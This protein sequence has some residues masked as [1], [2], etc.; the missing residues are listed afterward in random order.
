MKRLDQLNHEKA[1]EEINLEKIK[2]DA[3]TDQKTKLIQAEEE[4]HVSLI[5]AEGIKAQAEKRAK[6]KE[7][8]LMA[9]AKVYYT[10]KKIDADN[11]C[12]ILIKQAENRYEC[13]KNKS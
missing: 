7:E 2:I 11:I 10:A 8:E 3:L 12:E 4:R 6:K 1:I 5:N 9:E 13:A